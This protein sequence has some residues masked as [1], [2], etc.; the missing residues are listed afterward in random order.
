[1]DA[2]AQ[3]R[4]LPFPGLKFRAHFWSLSLV[5]H[6]DTSG[7]TYRINKTY[8]QARD[9][10]SLRV[11]WLCSQLMQSKD[12]ACHHTSRWQYSTRC[13]SARR[14]L[15]LCHVSLI[16]P[17]KDFT[18]CL[19]LSLQAKTTCCVLGRTGTATHSPHR[20]KAC[21]QI[22]GY[23]CW[24]SKIISLLCKNVCCFPFIPVCPAVP[25]ISWVLLKILTER[26]LWVALFSNKKALVSLP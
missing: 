24:G 20:S 21:V 18:P 2:L 19:N 12:R 13:L 17:C 26:P 11:T 5:S 6:P 10:F 3:R 25:T 16:S 4:L 15:W 22:K 1:M 7:A 9:A 14:T 8:F 23:K